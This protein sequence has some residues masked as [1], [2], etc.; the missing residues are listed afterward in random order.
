MSDT[1]TEIDPTSGDG[2]RPDEPDRMEIIRRS[3]VTFN[4]R[5]AL[6][7]PVLA[8]VTALFFSAIIIAISDVDNLE[9]LDEDFFGAIWEINESYALS[10]NVSRTER[11]PNAE[12]LYSDGPHLATLSLELGDPDKVH[13]LFVGHKRGDLRLAHREPL[14]RLGASQG[15]PQI[16]PEQRAASVGEVLQHGGGGVAGRQ[17]ALVFGAGCNV[18]HGRAA[19]PCPS[20]EGTSPP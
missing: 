2:Q 10:G 5:E 20:R 7:L 4:W 9:R 14:G 17:G 11:S 16:T 8:L 6:L 18:A 3:I 15:D 19:Y 12:E 1:A 13:L